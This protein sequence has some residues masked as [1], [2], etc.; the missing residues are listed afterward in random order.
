METNKYI[1]ITGQLNAGDVITESGL[2]DTEKDVRDVTVTKVS[3][4]VIEYQNSPMP[5]WYVSG[6]DN[7]TGKK[8]VWTSNAWRR[9]TVARPYPVKTKVS[10]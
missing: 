9:W 1:M 4:A 6:T 7:R 10:A 2:R 8:V 3:S 5:V